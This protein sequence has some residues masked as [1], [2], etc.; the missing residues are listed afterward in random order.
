MQI[1]DADEEH[2]NGKKSKFDLMLDSIVGNK[3]LNVIGKPITEMKKY[4]YYRFFKRYGK[5]KYSIIRNDRN[6][7]Y[8]FKEAIILYKDFVITITRDNFIESDDTF[9]TFY[10]K[11]MHKISKFEDE[12]TEWIKKNNIFRGKQFTFPELERPKMATAYFVNDSSRKL[13]EENTLLF[14]RKMKQLKESGVKPRRGIILYGNPGNGKTSI[15][16]WVSK[17]L[18]GVTRIWVTTWAIKGQM[19]SE[20]FEMAR[21]FA[22]SIIFMED[23]D[24]AGISRH[25]TGTVNPVLGRLLNEMDGIKKNDGIIVIATTNNTHVLDEALA[26]RPGRFDLKIHIGNPRPDLVKRI[27]GHEDDI[28]LAEAFRRKEDRIYYE[29]ILGRKYRQSR[30]RESLH[31]IG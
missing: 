30:K 5:I 4:D 20:L 12:L 29:K 10:H 11:N 19:I 2:R 17:K 16:R 8:F 6:W 24:T 25:H 22:P 15:C 26:K 14:F 28:T 13:I 1:I 9:L 23:I 3:K 7:G 21:D 27:T 18:P 31:Y